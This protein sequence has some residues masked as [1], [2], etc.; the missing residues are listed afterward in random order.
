MGL[1][2][3]PVCAQALKRKEKVYICK[4]NHCF[5]I[6][7]KGYTNLLPANRK[8]SAVPGDDK[9]MVTARNLF[10]SKGYY[11]NLREK[12]EEIAVKYTP[13]QPK[14]LDCGCGEG[15][16]TQGIAEALQ[17]SGKQAE[18]VGIDISKDAA[19]LGAK[20]TN[21]ADFAVASSLNLPKKRD[22]IDLLVNCFSPLCV[23]EF[24][25]VLKKGG[26]F[27]Y[28]V[29]GE[30]HLWELKCELYEKPYKNEE[31]QTEYDGF[32]YREVVKTEKD[33]FLEDGDA[34]QNLFKMTP[35]VWKTPQKD[36]ERLLDKQTLKVHTEFCIHIYTKK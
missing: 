11:S 35:Y 23:P 36:R 25:R 9:D 20:R 7:A 26:S 33:I 22:S 19:R 34:I 2:I 29:P 31:K 6:S 27:I 24:H 18:T 13:D 10:L 30:N 28:V 8:N 32:L 3:C 15:Y 4:N 5:D 14:V 16:Y 17:K 1:F 12:L 21:H